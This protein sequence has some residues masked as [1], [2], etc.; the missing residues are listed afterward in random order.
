MGKVG[1]RGGGDVMQIFFLGWGG[2]VGGVAA[3][4]EPGNEANE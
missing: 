2:G 4:K 1:E 3:I